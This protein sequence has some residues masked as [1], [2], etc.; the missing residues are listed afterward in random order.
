MGL[1]SSRSLYFAVQDAR[2]WRKNVFYFYGDA[3]SEST[4]TWKLKN[5]PK[6][7][8]SKI[9]NPK[10]KIVRLC[11]IGGCASDNQTKRGETPIDQNPATASQ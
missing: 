2:R 1:R 4:P 9:Q 7:L 10:S 8:K 3:P 5:Q 11:Q 6:N